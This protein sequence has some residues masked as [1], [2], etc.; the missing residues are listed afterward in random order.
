[1]S[2]IEHQSSCLQTYAILLGRIKEAS[3]LNL[4]EFWSNDHVGDLGIYERI[5]LQQ[6]T[7]NVV[8]SFRQEGD[9]LLGSFAVE[10]LRN[11]DVSKALTTSTFMAK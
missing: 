3:P 6:T 8:I 11:S 10:S 9:C 1:M 7:R 4:V 2:G 5:P